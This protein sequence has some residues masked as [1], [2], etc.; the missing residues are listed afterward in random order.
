MNFLLGNKKALFA[1]M[2]RY[3]EACDK[4]VFDYLPLTFHISKGIEDPEYFAFLKSYYAKE[5][6][7]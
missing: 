5:K 3:Y 6:Q 7:K 2:K 4:N 1:T